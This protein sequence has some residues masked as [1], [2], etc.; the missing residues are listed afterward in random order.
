M[1]VASAEC[2]DVREALGARPC[3]SGQA[4]LSGKIHM[5]AANRCTG[6]LSRAW[7]WKTGGHGVSAVWDQWENQVWKT[8]WQKVYFCFAFGD[9][10]LCT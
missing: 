2:A 6:E 5:M 1:R 8:R 9:R 3:G 7:G 4:G 10:V